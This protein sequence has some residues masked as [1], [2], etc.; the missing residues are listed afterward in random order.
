MTFGYNGNINKS[1]TA[2]PTA[3]QDNNTPLTMLNYAEIR[4][5]G[6]PALRWEK[7]QTIN[8]GYD[9]SVKNNVVLELL[10]FIL[11][12]GIDLFGNFVLAPSTGYTQFFGNFAGS[13]GHGFDLELTSNNIRGRSFQWSS[14]LQL[15]HVIDKVAKSEIGSDINALNVLIYGDGIQGAIVPLVGKPLFGVYS[16]KSAGLSHETGDPQG[17][18]NGKL[19]TDYAAILQATTIDSLFFIGQARPTLFGSLRNNLSFRRLSL[20]FNIVYKFNYYLRENINE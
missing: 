15:S 11:K 17:Y 13:K 6:N 19:S 2:A 20:S 16:Y 7:V 8:I 5:P 14:K 1:A 10:I 9:F 18:L 4:N 12:K 3:R